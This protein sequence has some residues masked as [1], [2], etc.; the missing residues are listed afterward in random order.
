MP[1]PLPEE[2]FTSGEPTPDDRLDSW[3]EVAA[4][5]RRDV[6]TVRRWEQALGLPVHRHRHKRGV[7][8]Y[9]YK[10]EVNAWWQQRDEA[11]EASV[12]PAQASG[13][14]GQLGWVVVAL[15]TTLGLLHSD[16][17]RVPAVEPLAQPGTVNPIPGAPSGIEEYPSVSPDARRLA[18]SWNG[19]DRRNF[20]IYLSEFDSPGEPLRLTRDPAADFNPTWSPDGRLIAFVR[21]TVPSQFNVMLIPAA[22]GE[23]RGITACQGAWDR[24]AG[25]YLAWT[26]DGRGLMVLQREPHGQAAGL[27]LLPHNA[28]RARRVVLP[29]DGPPTS[30]NEPA[31][32]P[33]ACLALD[34]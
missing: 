1:S 17:W 18:F 22:G 2:T 8:V 6:R 23:E 21:Q 32:G 30:T 9:A 15:L 19:A 31:G 27:L 25:S 12:R 14:F 10:G 26:P 28:G 4:H 7:S 5:F 33:S 34:R 29:V 11:R 3:K 24:Q 20:D 16:V 13:R